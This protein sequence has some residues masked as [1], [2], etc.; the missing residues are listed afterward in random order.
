VVIVVSLPSS[1]TSDVTGS[2][3][4]TEPQTSETLTT[5]TLPDGTTVSPRRPV[6]GIPSPSSTKLLF[7]IGDQANSAAATE[8]VRQ[9]PTR[10]LTT[11]FH[12]PQDIGRF[13]PWRKTLIPDA[14]ADGYAL[15][16]I[17]AS[18]DVEPTVA[19]DRG[20]GCGKP[21]PLTDGFLDHMHRLARIFAG[22]AD[23]PPLFVT[24]FH[25][26]NVYGDYTRDPASTTYYDAIKKRY[27]QAREIFHQ[28]APNARVALGFR[29][30]QANYDDPSIGGGLSMFPYFADMLR[31]SDFQ[32]VFSWERDTN[33]HHIHQAVQALGHYGP[34]MLAQYADNG[35]PSQRSKTTYRACSP[36]PPS[37]N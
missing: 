18:W 12:I 7:G 2:M 8:L 37:P 5:A 25:G 33:I 10:M 11:W 32:S 34:V 30:W 1:G 20:T 3:T 29:S 6:P 4:A 19:T 21:Y 27:L 26:V 17:V 28:E 23:D 16:L 24:V 9:T 22:K 14:Y 31:I 15:H 36:T 13:H 35:L